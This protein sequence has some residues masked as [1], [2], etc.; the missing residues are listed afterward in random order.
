MTFNQIQQRLWE[1]VGF[2]KD[3]DSHCGWILFIFNLFFESDLF[4][5]HT[6]FF[7]SLFL[8]SESFPTF[9]H[10]IY[11]R[12]EKDFTFFHLVAF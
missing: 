2:L 3:L 5:P 11:S 10:Q 9:F 4:F 7:P 1:F 12:I 8:I 6:G